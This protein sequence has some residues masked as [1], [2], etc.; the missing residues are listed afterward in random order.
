MNLVSSATPS[1]P[2]PPTSNAEGKLRSC[3]GR[4]RLRSRFP[5][6]VIGVGSN[7]F[8]Q[9]FS[10]GLDV[11]YEKGTGDPVLTLGT[12]PHSTLWVGGHISSA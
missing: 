4:G 3:H 6:V 12:P 9:K 7:E 8:S 1:P 5:A 11:S 2:C 10:P